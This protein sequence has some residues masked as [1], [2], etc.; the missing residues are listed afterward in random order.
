MA[1]ALVVQKKN[2]SPKELKE[3]ARAPFFGAYRIKR[4]TE[5]ETN[6]KP[7]R[8]RIK[9]Y[10]RVSELTDEELLDPGTP[11]LSL[12]PGEWLRDNPLPPLRLASF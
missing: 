8:R 5:E 7:G 1:I 12:T 4:A 11:I 2:H 10:P 3:L 6:G 9:K